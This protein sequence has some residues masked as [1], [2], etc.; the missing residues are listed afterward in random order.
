MFS[1]YFQLKFE[2]D[3]F[4]FYLNKAFDLYSNIYSIYNTKKNPE[5]LL[6]HCKKYSLIKNKIKAEK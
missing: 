5:Y 1:S 6:L 3:Y 4:K 2:H